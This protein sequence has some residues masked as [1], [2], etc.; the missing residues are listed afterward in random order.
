MEAVNFWR[1]PCNIKIAKRHISF[2]I[3]KVFDIKRHEFNITFKCFVS[4]R[5]VDF[6]E[7]YLSS[8]IEIT[9]EFSLEWKTMALEN[10]KSSGIF[11]F[12]RNK[13]KK[14]NIVVFCFLFIL[15]RIAHLL[16]YCPAHQNNKMLVS[17]PVVYILKTLIQK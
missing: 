17:K 5:L 13:G 6:K 7:I 1:F 14:A 11:P 9:S 16:F 8:Y 4:F 15:L 12:I 2:L 3:S 10:G